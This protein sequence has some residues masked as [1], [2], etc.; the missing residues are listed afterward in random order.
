MDVGS[1]EDKVSCESSSISNGKGKLAL[2]APVVFVLLKELVPEE[3]LRH[4]EIGVKTFSPLI[5]LTP[6]LKRHILR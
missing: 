5:A 2:Y 3:E 4:L 6:A 1:M